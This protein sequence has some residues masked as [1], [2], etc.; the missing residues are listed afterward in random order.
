MSQQ[1]LQIYSKYEIIT[2]ETKSQVYE[3]MRFMPNEDGLPAI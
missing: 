1:L 3:L 2:S